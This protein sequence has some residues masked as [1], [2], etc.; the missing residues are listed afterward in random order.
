VR[1][2]QFGVGDVELQLSWLGTERSDVVDPQGASPANHDL[3]QGQ[4]ETLATDV[5]GSRDEGD[6]GVARETVDGREIEIGGVA[7]VGEVAEAEQGAPLEDEA[8]VANGAD[9]RA[10]MGEHVVALDGLSG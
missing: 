6:G 8:S 5:N 9:I 10:Q 7:V 2:D 3:Q 1:F 4:F